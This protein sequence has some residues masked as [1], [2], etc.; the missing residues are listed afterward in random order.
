MAQ[1]LTKEELGISYRIATVRMHQLITEFYED[2]FNILGDPRKDPAAI[3]GISSS[4]RSQMEIEFDMIKEVCIEYME[5]HID[6][7]TTAQELF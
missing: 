6:D 5:S 7:H 3:S 1:P 4:C 2:L